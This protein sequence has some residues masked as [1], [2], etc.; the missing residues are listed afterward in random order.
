MCPLCDVY[1]HLYTMQLV[2]ILL[3]KYARK[4][5]LSTIIIITENLRFKF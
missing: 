5:L 2:S 1:L 4:Y 3:N